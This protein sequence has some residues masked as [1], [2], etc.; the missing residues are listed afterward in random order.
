MDCIDE[1]N[2]FSAILRKGDYRSDNIKVISH[3]RNNN[4]KIGK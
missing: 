2:I 4:L 1:L 3:Y